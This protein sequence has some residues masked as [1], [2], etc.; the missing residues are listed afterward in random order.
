MTIPVSITVC[1]DTSKLQ[2]AL[3]REHLNFMAIQQ[4]FRLVEGEEVPHYKLEPRRMKLIKSADGTQSISTL[5][6]CCYGEEGE[7]IGLFAALSDVLTVLATGTNN[8]GEDC[9]WCKLTEEQWTTYVDPIQVSYLPD[10]EGEPTT[11]KARHA[12]GS[13]AQSSR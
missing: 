11:T 12:L 13:C 9:P 7:L 6:G 3:A 1:Q 5:K 8:G 4:S 10:T 2:A